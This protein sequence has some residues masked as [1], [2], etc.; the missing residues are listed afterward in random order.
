MSPAVASSRPRAALRLVAVGGSDRLMQGMIISTAPLLFLRFSNNGIVIGLGNAIQYSSWVLFGL[1]AGGLADL[2][3]RADLIRIS[4]WLRLALACLASVLAATSSL[5]VAWAIAL[6]ALLACSLV[7]TDTAINASMPALFDRDELVAVNSRLSVAQSIAG[8]VAPVLAT[9]LL[10]RGETWLFVILALPTIVAL[11]A[12]TTRRPHVFGKPGSGRLR[13]LDV[14]AGFRTVFAVP[15]LRTLLVGVGLLNLVGGAYLTILPVL[16]LVDRGLSSGQYGTA[17]AIQAATLI[18][19]NILVARRITKVPG[20]LGHLLVCSFAMRVAS[21]AIVGLVASYAALL[22]AM[23][24]S[25]SALALWNVPASS[26][27]LEATRGENAGST[28]ASFRM[29][30]L[31]WTPLGAAA[32]G[33]ALTRVDGADIVLALSAM[34]AAGSLLLPLLL[35]RSRT[36]DVEV[37]R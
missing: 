36:A 18:G 21:L 3:D 19:A 11:L 7:F 28:V 2:Y 12:T 29:A 31:L 22:V 17:L 6:V 27:A 32:G 1:L 33:L 37:S 9:T 10:G 16:T 5:N 14:T 4:S 24:L 13:D 34:V 8:V 15:M 20:C 25:G 23:I 35:R 30:A 26:I